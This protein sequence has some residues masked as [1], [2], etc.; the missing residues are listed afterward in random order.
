M[1]WQIDQSTAILFGMTMAIL[2]LVLIVAWLVDTIIRQNATLAED[3]YT[4]HAACTAHIAEMTSKRWGAVILRDLADRYDSA[5]EVRVINQIK[6]EQWKPE[7]PVLPVL[8]L[9]YHADL[10]D[11]PAGDEK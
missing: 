8:W 1:N 11:P 4:D 6:R 2:A 9:R 5:A 7:G 10:L 3:D